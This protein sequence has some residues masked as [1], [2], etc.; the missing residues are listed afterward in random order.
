MIPKI[1]HYCWFGGEKPTLVKKCIESWEKWCGDYQIIEWNENN[2]DVS[3]SVYSQGAYDLKHYA[4]L[5]DYIRIAILAEYGGIYLDT[6]VELLRSLD[7]LLQQ[8]AFMAA[9]DDFYVASGLGVGAKAAHPFFTKMLAFYKSIYYRYN[10]GTTNHKSSP[11]YITE[12]LVRMGYR[13]MGNKIRHVGEIT[14]YPKEYFSPASFW[15]PTPMITDHTYAWH[16]GMASWIPQLLKEERAAY[17]INSLS[18]FVSPHYD[19][20]IGSCAGWIHRLRQDNIHVEVL[21][22][23]S[24][25][26]LCREM[27]DELASKLMDVSRK[28]LGY[29]ECISRTDNNGQLL[30][31]HVGDE[32][33][34]VRGEDDDLKEELL[35]TFEGYDKNLTHF[36][37]PAGIGH[38]V[39][40]LVLHDVGM[41]LLLKGWNVTFYADFSYQGSFPANL[42]ELIYPL[43]EEQQVLKINAIKC[44][45]SQIYRLFQSEDG[46]QE[47][48]CQNIAN[49][50]YYLPVSVD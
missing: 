32:F 34:L 22:V 10:D 46:W 15:E 49:E 50:R 47:Y 9:E 6:D 2:F 33:M 13:H 48:L 5:S 11:V 44:Y 36:Y 16:H 21:T 39:D 19:D 20:A 43:N 29:A 8:P 7:D 38:Q 35:H 17:F 27:E 12:E 4:F 3:Q 14:I 23:M 41:I 31:P 37:F 24:D 28:T 25:T 1:I 45:N 18:V 30:Y 26:D 40:H 42:K